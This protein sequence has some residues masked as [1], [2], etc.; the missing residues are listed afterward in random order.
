MFLFQ[1]WLKLLCFL[2]L[3][4]CETNY[5]LFF[6]RLNSKYFSMTY[7]LWKYIGLCLLTNLSKVNQTQNVPEIR[8][9]WPNSTHFLLNFLV[10][11]TKRTPLNSFLLFSTAHSLFIQGR[12]RKRNIKYNQPSVTLE[13]LIRQ[14]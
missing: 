13:H 3:A 11:S 9:T 2:C 5:R 14:R 7:I 4:L 6:W 12:Q 8:L 1:T 10:S